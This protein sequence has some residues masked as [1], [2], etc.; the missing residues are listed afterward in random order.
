MK[1]ATAKLY[2][3]H[4]TFSLVLVS[5]NHDDKVLLLDEDTYPLIEKLSEILGYGGVD[6]MFRD[7]QRGDETLLE[8]E[9]E[10]ENGVPFDLR[11]I[12]K[13]FESFKRNIPAESTVEV[14][15]ELT[16]NYQSDLAASGIE[17]IYE[18]F[19]YRIL[20]LMKELVIDRLIISSNEVKDQHR[21]ITIISKHAPLADVE[22][23]LDN[24]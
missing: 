6:E 12:S 2:K 11:L 14:T 9:R 1:Q 17:C 18:N 13:H 10:F 16:T 4:D 21:L 19:V 5:E 24:E 23:V 7:A 20:N 22:V 3:N 8:L 15:T